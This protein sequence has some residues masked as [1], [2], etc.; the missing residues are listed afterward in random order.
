MIGQRARALL[1]NRCEPADEIE[2][3]ASGPHLA[4][5]KGG[6]G[7]GPAELTARTLASRGRLISSRTRS[8][9]VCYHSLPPKA[10]IDC[11]SGVLTSWRVLA[12]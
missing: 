4:K 5:N 9:L 3:H 8:T 2:G 11:R 7:R 12:G 10:A 6:F 1:P